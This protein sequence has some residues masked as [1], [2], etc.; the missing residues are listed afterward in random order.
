MK[1]MKKAL[2]CNTVSSLA[3]QLISVAAG[4]IIPRLILTY[5]GSETNGLI[6]SITQ[7]LGIIGFLDLGIGQVYRSSL[8][9]PLAEKDTE[10]ISAL[11]SAASRFYR[12]VAY[13]LLFYVLILILLY[14]NL[15]EC[16]FDLG[17]TSSMI[18]VLA[19]GSFSQYYFGLVDSLLLNSKQCSDDRNNFECSYLSGNDHSRLVYSCS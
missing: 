7:F 15:V 4:L 8:Y 3:V 13:A 2:L 14:P 17:Y 6:Q 16:K 11:T 5:Y 18:A 1:N 10:Q 12:G 9:S 19:I